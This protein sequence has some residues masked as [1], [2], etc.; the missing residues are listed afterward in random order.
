MISTM[1][2]HAIYRDT[3]NPERLAWEWTP[4][5]WPGESHRD[6]DSPSPIPPGW[7]VAAVFDVQ[8]PQP[9]NVGE[10]GYVGGPWDGPLSLWSP[11]GAIEYTPAD[12]LRGEVPPGVTVLWIGPPVKP[13]RH[14][15]DD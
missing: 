11:L 7:S 3:A 6:G 2:R 15:F 5:P 13:Y 14:I 10:L 9:W 4:R 12:V 8:D 1:S